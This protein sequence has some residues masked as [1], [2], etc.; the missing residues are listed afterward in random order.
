MSNPQPRKVK[1]LVV[2]G[3]AGFVLIATLLVLMQRVAGPGHSGP[4]RIAMGTAGMAV[5]VLWWVYFAV[6]I[7]RSQDEYQRWAETRAWYWGGLMGLMASAPVFMFIGMGGLHLLNPLT[8]T[9]PVASRAFATGYM[10]PLM[11]QVGG[12]SLYALWWRLARR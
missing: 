12:A 8:D 3:F 7:G 2:I 6:R 4:A 11:M 9:G 5:L 1:G 10:L